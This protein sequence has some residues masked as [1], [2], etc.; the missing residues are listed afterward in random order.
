[1]SFSSGSLRRR[2]SWLDDGWY[3]ERWMDTHQFLCMYS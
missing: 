2:P 3:I 1:V